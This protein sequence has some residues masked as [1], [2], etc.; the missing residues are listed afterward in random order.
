MPRWTVES[1]CEGQT[2]RY[3]DPSQQTRKGHRYDEHTSR[4]VPGSDRKSTGS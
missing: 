4:V 1:R 3:S 2:D